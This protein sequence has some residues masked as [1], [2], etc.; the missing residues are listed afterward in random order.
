M[1]QSIPS[2]HTF[3]AKLPQDVRAMVRVVMMRAEYR[4]A[5]TL[6]QKVDILHTSEFS[7]PLLL[8]AK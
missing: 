5:E 1:D 8:H 7:I 6:N 3:E 4:Q 2:Q